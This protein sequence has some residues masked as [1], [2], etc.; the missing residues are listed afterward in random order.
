MTGHRPGATVTVPAISLL[1]RVSGS[2]RPG[3]NAV[4]AA[5]ALTAYACRT[6]QL[7]GPIADV[8]ELVTAE[9]VGNAVRHAR[10]RVG[11]TVARSP[12][13]VHI[14]V[15]DYVTAPARLSVPA[16]LSGPAGE[17]GALSSGRGLM[18]VDALATHWG[19]TR[20]DTAAGPGKITWAALATHTP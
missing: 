15:R 13:R 6:W 20:V 1:S 4:Q 9:L 8:A 10:T 7:A 16:R 14:A 17:P 5:R 12:R 18:I 3:P 19:C 11:V 2:Y